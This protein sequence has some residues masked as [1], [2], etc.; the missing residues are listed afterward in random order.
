M[1]LMRKIWKNK[2]KKKRAGSHGI[3][4]VFVTLM[5]VP[6]VAITGIMVD[7]ARLNLY[8]SQAVMAAD[9]YGDAVLSEFDNLLKELYGL[10]SV[11]QNKEGLEAVDNLAETV[12]YSF[13]P[14]GDGKSLSGFMPYKDADVKISYEKVD[15]ASL[16]N[17]N[18]LMTQISDFMKYRIVEEV[19]DENGIL[20]SL[21][22]FDY[23]DA[24]M[25]AAKKRTEISKSS[26]KAMEKIQE[27][28]E[29]LDKI[30]QYPDYL[31]RMGDG[32]DAYSA[33]LRRAVS[34]DEYEKYVYYLEHQDEIDAAL[35]EFGG[36]D[37]EDD[38]NDN[39]SGSGNQADDNSDEDDDD[40][41]DEDLAHRVELYDQ[42][43][44][45]DID[46]YLDDLEREL[47][48]AESPL[49]AHAGDPINFDNA[50]GLIYA[51]GEKANE[52]DG[53]FRTIQEQVNELEEQLKSCSDDIREGIQN[54]IKDL[55]QI[56]E[57]SAEFKKVYELIEVRNCDTEK[58][59][60][61]KE[62]FEREMQLLTAVRENILSGN[63]QPRDEYWTKHLSLVWYDFM[64]DK[65]SKELYNA[66]NKI[67]T[68]DTDGE[69][70]KKA[71]DKQIKRANKEQEKAEKKLNGN[72][73][74]SARNIPAGIASQ[75]QDGKNEDRVPG[76]TEYFSDGL[77][78]KKAA[79]SAA[80]VLDKFLVTSYDFGM[81]SSRVTGVK[82]PETKKTDAADLNS[83]TDLSADIADSSSEEKDS[84]KDE[85]LTGYEMSP[86]INY[87]YGAELE[88]L[89][90]GHNESVKNLN[91]SRNIICGVRE[92][93][94][95]I[96]SYKIREINE[97]I[98]T[99]AN[100]AA[101]AVVASGVGAP[102]APLVRVAVSGALRLAFA[103]IETVGDWTELKERDNVVFLKSEMSELKSVDALSDLL[104][105]DIPEPSSD[106]KFGLSYEDYMFV[107][108]C[109]F[110]DPNTLL[111]RT[112]NLITLNMN[113]AK[114]KGDTLST[115]DFKMQ[116]TVTAVKSTCKVKADFVVLPDNFAEM[117]YSGTKTE[118]QIERLENLYFGYSVIRGY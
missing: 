61:N 94:N 53:S 3:I 7:V 19:L 59:Y 111:A 97:A 107:L 51:L 80:G 102:A 85:S 50:G 33:Q 118:S 21:S 10:F 95:F 68:A 58:N 90:G 86:D 35:E 39:E 25:T 89:L 113:Q 60:N 105:I 17:N 38:D 49:I 70:N 47:L 14:T 45:F 2:K 46:E 78:F 104:G 87:L 117:F 40:E 72:E 77:S 112:S 37:E 24:D 75:L 55:K 62:T 13:N 1:K 32:F 115:L 63:V 8:S 56:L 6:V 84:Y 88:Y 93:M 44:D 26:Q 103:S 96:S 109:I 36:D 34:T 98:N 4:T 65:D 43:K 57:L 73:E 82:P 83:G 54:E 76:F 101:E 74:T 30:R 29:I 31:N 91:H 81:F 12:G 42:Y 22:Q 11:T 92:T 9:T 114:N 106:K 108:L 110:T 5:M 27:Y 67:C 15:G 99:V 28:F 20:S 18:V 52:L 116:D 66:L 16:S 41:E 100:T 23:M 48:A 79:D 69:G 71:G 64:D